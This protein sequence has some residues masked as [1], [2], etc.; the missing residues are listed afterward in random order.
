MI[1][2]VVVDDHPLFRDGLRGLLESLPGMQV[3]G[4]AGDGATAIAL[5]EQLRPDVMLIDV[6]MPGVN[7]I[8]AT[9]EISALAPTVA[10]LVVTML[11]DDASLLAAVRAGARGYLRKDAS[12]EEVRI[13]VEAVAQGQSVLAPG[14]VARLLASAGTRPPA[15]AFPELTEREEEVLRLVAAGRTNADIAAT[16]A[17]S[18]KTVRNHL[19]NILAK[20]RVADRAQ[21]ALRAREAGL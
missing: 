18:L 6:A 7:G 4:E 2:L 21:A 20:L 19:S 13:A 15:R 5:A 11:D 10:V 9:A 1:R 12:R 8:A 3:I 14:L 16:L 17:L